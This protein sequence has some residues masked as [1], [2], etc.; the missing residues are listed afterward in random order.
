[1]PQTEMQRNQVGWWEREEE[2]LLVSD[3]TKNCRK[4]RNKENDVTNGD[5]DN[6]GTLNVDHED[7]E[8]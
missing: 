5:G 6:N 1:M 7:S 8:S 4:K 3:E 2:K